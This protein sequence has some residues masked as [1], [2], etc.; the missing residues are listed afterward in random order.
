[1]TLSLICGFAIGLAALVVNPA[2]AADP[3]AGKKKAL[4]CAVCHGLDGLHKLPEAPNLAGDSAEYISKQLKDF[5]TGARRHEQMSI[6]AKGLSDEDIDNLAA[7][8][9]S[10]KVTVEMPK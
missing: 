3:V 9:S 10:L 6:I 5:Q 7:W 1:M 8:Y 2:W 4:A